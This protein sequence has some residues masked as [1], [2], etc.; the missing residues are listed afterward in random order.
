MFLL[1][2]T[3]IVNN[4]YG[5]KKDASLSIRRFFN[6]DI[7]IK[8]QENNLK[9]KIQ[10]QINNSTYYIVSLFIKQKLSKY[11]NAMCENLRTRLIL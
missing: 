7:I 8:R 9:W 4:S 10:P 5:R 6:R 3:V 2:Y 11:L 1:K